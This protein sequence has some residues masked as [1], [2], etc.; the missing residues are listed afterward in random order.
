MVLEMTKV[1][2]AVCKPNSF[3]CKSLLQVTQH[4]LLVFVVGGTKVYI[5]PGGMMKSNGKLVE[6][7]ERV[8]PEIRTLIEKCNTVGL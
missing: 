2:F 1:S 7:I 4:P 3:C 6:L 5:M 8:K